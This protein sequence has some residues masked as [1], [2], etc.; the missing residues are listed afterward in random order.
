M[1]FKKVLF[2]WLFFFHFSLFRN[3]FF[4]YF[5]RSLYIYAFFALPEKISNSDYCSE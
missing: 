3:F 5:S 4:L 2:N 1:D